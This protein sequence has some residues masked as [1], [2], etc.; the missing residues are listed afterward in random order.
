MLIRKFSTAKRINPDVH[1]FN[2][3]RI[4]DIVINTDKSSV[5][6]LLQKFCRDPDFTVIQTFPTELQNTSNGLGAFLVSV[7]M[8][9]INL[10]FS[11][12]S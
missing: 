5:T 12:V 3:G 4:F 11:K 2:F 6:P 1:L 9:P 10:L 8:F 7:L